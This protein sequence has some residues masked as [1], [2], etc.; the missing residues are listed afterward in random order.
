MSAIRIRVWVFTFWVFGLLI[1][2]GHALA[3]SLVVSTERA[4][5]GAPLSLAVS[6]PGE[7]SED[8]VV[9]LRRVGED[10]SGWVWH[11]PSDPPWQFDGFAPSDPGMHEFVLLKGD[12]ELDVV[13]LRT[14]VTPVPGAITLEKTDF[15]AGENMHVAVNLPPDRYYGQPWV[16]LFEKGVLGRGGASLADGRL[17]WQRAPMDGSGMVF[18]APAAPGEYILRLFD[19]DAWRYQLDTA[20]FNVSVPRTPGALSTE[21][22]DYV[23]GEAITVT[24]TLPEG[25]YANAAWVGLF[26]V[27]KVPEG[28]EA[29]AERNRLTWQRVNLE[30]G[31]NVFSAPIWPGDYEFRI[32]DRD[33]WFY[34]LD[35]T[36]ISVSV[37]PVPGALMLDHD[38][39]TVGEQIDLDVMLPEGRYYGSPWVGLFTS[40]GQEVAGGATVAGNRQTWQRV[41]FET[42]VNMFTAPIWPGRYEFKVYDRDNWFYELDTVAFE[43]E[44]PPVPDA[45]S[46]ESEVFTVGAPI[47]VSYDLPDGRYYG[48]PWIGLFRSDEEAMGGAGIARQRLDWQRVDLVNGQNTFTAPIW[49]GK[50]EFRVFDRDNW[51]YELDDIGFEVEAPPVPDALSLD[52]D[53]YIT[54]APVNLSV[55]LPGGRYYGSPWVGLFRSST[56][57]DRGGAGLGLQRL[58]WQRVDL[59]G[60]SNLFTAPAWPGEYEF[61]VF[62]RDDWNYEL[63]RIGFSVI[64][65]PAPRALSLEQTVFNAG[66][67]IELAVSL[68]EGRYLSSPW[69]GLF[70]GTYPIESG[71][72][73][74]D[75]TDASFLDRYRLDWQR[76]NTED[77]VNIF[78]AP[79]WPGLYEFRVFDRDGSV[80]VLDPIAFEVI[81]PPGS[82]LGVEPAL[83]E[84]GGPLIVAA[85][86]PEG[87][88]SSGAY[89]EIVQ[90]SH[91]VDGNAAVGE[92]R[93]EWH[94]VKEAQQSFDLNAPTEPGPYE[95]RFYDRNWSGYILDIVLF[96][97]R[98]PSQAP[99]ERQRDRFTPLPG[100]VGSASEDDPEIPEVSPPEEDGAFTVRDLRFV[101]PLAVGTETRYVALDHVLIGQAFMVEATVEYPPD[102][103]VTVAVM[104]PVG[105]VQVELIPSEDDRDVYRSGLLMASPDGN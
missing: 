78:T 44:V 98:D 76:V 42:G 68:P 8:H 46:L 48:S 27:D 20:N 32:Y 28:D 13:A 22:R 83:A 75:G 67:R 38:V 66:A 11:L 15:R 51:F 55:Q 47:T 96:D 10:F 6:L 40:D 91:R 77:G 65:P 24:T 33:E 50:Y 18:S 35:T 69:V 19:R 43:V 81:V 70:R 21:K 88:Y 16:G 36:E 4:I 103:G 31:K 25:T 49:P 72:G 12:V 99:L 92:R 5:V 89:I 39:Y 79:A 53:T 104:T 26:S 14:L 29:G 2:A 97:V 1:P 82:L 52:G 101:R 94:W 30:T 34:L 45:L 86:L 57:I 84:P 3:Q 7:Q 60:G 73:L 54:G 90:S 102:G 85:S 74:T 87:R 58:D 95:V 93:V 17:N 56:E 63:D 80:F 105:E 37:P 61:R 71:R 9:R 41:N 59:A 64:A 100:L 62:D 23:V